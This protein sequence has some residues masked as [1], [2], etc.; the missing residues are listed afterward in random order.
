M[1]TKTNFQM[2]PAKIEFM[3]HWNVAG[4]LVNP[5]GMTLN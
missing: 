4:A 5:N 1:K 2:Y 3:T